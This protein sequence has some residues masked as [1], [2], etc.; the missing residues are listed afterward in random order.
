MCLPSSA[1]TESQHTLL[2]RS[3]GWSHLLIW[4]VSILKRPRDLFAFV[5]HR[6]FL[7]VS[8]WY[9]G[10]LSA[11][12][13]SRDSV[14]LDFSPS[15]AITPRCGLSLWYPH[16]LCLPGLGG[17][18]A[19]NLFKDSLWLYQWPLNNISLALFWCL[20][21]RLTATTHLA[22]WFSFLI[23]FGYFTERILVV[24]LL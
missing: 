21:K 23:K 12:G 8:V 9:W 13:Y 2:Y 20:H 4:T 1:L 7:S 22:F 3:Q 18:P 11:A 15:C 6:C 17:L 5:L 10:M 16:L 14:W 24:Q 19:A